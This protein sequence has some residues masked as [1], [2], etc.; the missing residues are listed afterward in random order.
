MTI[1]RHPFL[2]PFGAMQRPDLPLTVHGYDEFGHPDDSQAVSYIR[3]YS[4][5]SNISHSR[6]N[7]GGGG[8]GGG[9]G[10]GRVEGGGGVEGR[11]GE[12]GRVEGGRGVEGR[13]GG[14][15]G[16]GV[17]GR[18]GEGG[19]E[20]RG[21]GEGGGVEGRGGGGELGEEGICGY[22]AMFLSTGLLDMKV[23]PWESMHWVRGV[24]AAQERNKREREKATLSSSSICTPS[25]SERPVL[26]HITPNCGHDGPSDPE[27]DVRLKA[28]EIVFMEN[29]I[30]QRHKLINLN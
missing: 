14:G 6:R 17:E 24:R 26:L 1:C 29:A 3:S 19:G 15:G 12:G 18:G 2:D 21:E 16:G 4:P 13:V 9:G 7:K 11:G 23:S 20:G 30:Q 10:E 5:C 22:P 25:D 28:L 8:R 27:G